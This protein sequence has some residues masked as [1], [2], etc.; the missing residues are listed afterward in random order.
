METLKIGMKQG[1]QDQIRAQR[2]G[3]FRFKILL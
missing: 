1:L 2:Q 3:E